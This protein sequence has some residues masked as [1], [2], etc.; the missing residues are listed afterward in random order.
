MLININDATVATTIKLLASIN[1]SLSYSTLDEL[2]AVLKHHQ[3][4]FQNQL[5]LHFVTGT[6]MVII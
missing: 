3:Q 4:N 6:T 2:E 1:T 5:P